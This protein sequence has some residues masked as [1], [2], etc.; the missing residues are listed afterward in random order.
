M[1]N[2]L[3]KVSR[4]F[5]SAHRL[6][7]VVL[8]RPYEDEAPARLIAAAGPALFDRAAALLAW[9][10]EPGPPAQRRTVWGGGGISSG[11]GAAPL[12]P[13]RHARSRL[14]DLSTRP[15]CEQQGCRSAAR[16]S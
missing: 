8:R 7:L 1:H 13:A 15:P 3:R 11:E 9:L 4:I 6:L 14:S 16:C 2:L 12:K 5:P 10:A